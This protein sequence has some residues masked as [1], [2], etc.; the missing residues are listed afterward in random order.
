MMFKLRKATDEVLYELSN[1]GAAVCAYSSHL[2]Q[3]S[4]GRAQAACYQTWLRVRRKA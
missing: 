2:G 4:E 3:E 1:Q